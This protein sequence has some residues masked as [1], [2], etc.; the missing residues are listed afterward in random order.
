MKKVIIV[1][2]ALVGFSAASFAQAVAVKKTTPSKIQLVKKQTTATVPSKVVALNK[3]TTPSAKTVTAP[4]AT[5]MVAL[6]KV[7]KQAPAAAVTVPV[8]KVTTATPAIKR[9]AV[10]K[11]VAVA[12]TNSAVQLKKD[13][14]PDKRFKTNTDVASS[15]LKKDGTPDMRYKGNKKH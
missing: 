5:K 13:G 15:P 7:T 2:L 8:A 14:T 3:V 10:T 9:V 11:P 1:A 12:N 6:N 4:A